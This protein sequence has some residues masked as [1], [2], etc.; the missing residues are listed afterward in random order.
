MLLNINN[1]ILIISVRLKI[2]QL[3]KEHHSYMCFKYCAPTELILD[4]LGLDSLVLSYFQ[5]GNLY[6]RKPY[7]KGKIHGRYELYYYN[8]QLRHRQY[9]INGSQ[10]DGNYYYYDIKGA[11]LEEGQIK[12]GNV[13]GYSKYYVCDNL[14]WIRKFDKKGNFKQLYV[15]DDEKLRWKKSNDY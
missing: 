2:S 11:I 7:F 9:F 6:E 14:F 13:I 1:I 10:I 8:G 5:N 4:T 3:T 15:R 12:N